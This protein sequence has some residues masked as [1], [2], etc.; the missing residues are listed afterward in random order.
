MEAL[1]DRMSHDSQHIEE[2]E[3]AQW[4]NRHISEL[5]SSTDLCITVYFRSPTPPPGGHEQRAA[6]LERLGTMEVQD[7]ID[8]YDIRI[9]GSEVCLCTTCQGTVPAA[10]I[11]ET[12]TELARWRDGNMTSTGF[13]ERE[14][15]CSLTTDQYR[16]LVPPET[17]VGV[18]LDD[19]LTGVF[20]SVTDGTHYTVETFLRSL[21]AHASRKQASSPTVVGDSPRESHRG[22]Q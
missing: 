11:F 7:V 12:V 1:I 2:R 9:L 4:W 13:R 20:P 6:I 8:G 16:T 18:Y 17:A 21:P 15:N 3:L 14:V 5:K 10:Q 22:A 19:S